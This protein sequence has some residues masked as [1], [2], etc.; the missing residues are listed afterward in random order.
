MF[1]DKRTPL[2]LAL[3][4]G[5]A[6]GAGAV[7]VYLRKSRHSRSVALRRASSSHGRGAVSRK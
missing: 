6:V 2:V 1:L 5:L 7:A 4:I 3:V